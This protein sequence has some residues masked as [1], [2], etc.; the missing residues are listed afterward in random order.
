MSRDRPEPCDAALGEMR[1]EPEKGQKEL[2]SPLEAPSAVCCLLSDEYTT[3]LRA[4]QAAAAATH[5]L[6]LPIGSFFFI[7]PA[8]HDRD[9]QCL[10]YFLTN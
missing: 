8:N 10:E 4:C 7:S 5:P 2:L 3:S 1:R 6:P 9:H